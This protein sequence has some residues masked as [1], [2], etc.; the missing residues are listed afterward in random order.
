MDRWERLFAQLEAEQSSEE[1]VD[2]R[3]TAYEVSQAETRNIAL[4]DRM[5]GHLGSRLVLT[6]ETGELVDGQLAAV[7]PEWLLL[8]ISGQRTLIPAQ[9]VVTFRNLS[10]KPVVQEHSEGSS[11]MEEDERHSAALAALRKRSRE[12]SLEQVLRAIQSDR[13]RIALSAGPIE[14]LGM[15]VAVGTDHLDVH[16]EVERTPHTQASVVVTVSAARITKIVLL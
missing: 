14:V 16:T 10:R 12:W 4:V 8:T 5:R 11:E 6:L 1:S 15:I 9:A 13:E 3:A 7:E 2:R